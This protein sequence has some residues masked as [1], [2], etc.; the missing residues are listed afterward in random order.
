MPALANHPMPRKVYKF[1]GIDLVEQVLTGLVTEHFQ[2]YPDPV[3]KYQ[4][5]DGPRG[6]G[7]LESALAQPRQT[8]DGQ[9]LHR[10]VFDKAAALWR[11]ITLGHPF[12]DGNKRM[13]LLCCHIFLA[14]NGYLLIAPQKEA[15]D[16]CVEIASGQKSMS[17]KQIAQWLR[18]NTIA[19]NQERLEQFFAD[20][21]N[22]MSMVTDALNELSSVTA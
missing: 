1:I 5:L 12:I 22:Y 18:R 11:S 13:G 2:D 8:Y 9:Y 4:Y 3:P 17:L 7:K 19:T 6:Q 21:P 14:M 10:T 20:E 16:I 15:V